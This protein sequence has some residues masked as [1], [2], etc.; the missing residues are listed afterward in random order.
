MNFSMGL[1]FSCRKISTYLR[2]KVIFI[3]LQCRISRINF[4]C[5]VYF[6]GFC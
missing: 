1:E 3:D 2:I 5:E 4:L 6:G